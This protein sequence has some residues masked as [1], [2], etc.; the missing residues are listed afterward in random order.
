MLRKTLLYT[1]LALLLVGGVLGWNRLTAIQAATGDEGACPEEYSRYAILEP[2]QENGLSSN[3]IEQGCQPE[4]NAEKIHLNPIRPGDE[5]WEVKPYQPTEQAPLVQGPSDESI[6]RCVVF[7]EPVQPGAEASRASEPVCATGKIDMVDG[8]S[9]NS[10]YLIA[11]FY[12][13]T[14]YTT[15][16]IEYYG[17]SA[18]SSTISYGVTSLPSNLDNRFASGQSFSNCN[19]IHVYDFTNYGGPSY[20]C[21]PNCSSFYALNDNVSS[22]RTNQ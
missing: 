8:H 7:L 15:L 10:S 3:V 2:V 6:H 17:A 22:W 12:D 21:G 13:N 20:S 1:I 14:N 19:Q 9:L 5:D 18:C 4:V 11:K 16:L